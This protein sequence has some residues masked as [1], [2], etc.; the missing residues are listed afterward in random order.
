M[1]LVRGREISRGEMRRL[2]PALDDARRILSAFFAL[3]PLRAQSY[4]TIK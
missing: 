1:R 4:A 3:F 2:S